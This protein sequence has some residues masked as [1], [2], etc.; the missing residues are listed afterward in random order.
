MLTSVSQYT[1]STTIQMSYPVSFKDSYYIQVATKN[2]ETTFYL[3]INFFYAGYTQAII[4]CKSVQN[5]VGVKI[6]LMK[7]F[8]HKYLSSYTSFLYNS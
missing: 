6:M 7:W 5:K 2:I 3:F 1:F 8:C 4:N